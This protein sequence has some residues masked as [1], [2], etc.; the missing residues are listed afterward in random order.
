MISIMSGVANAEIAEDFIHD[1]KE[2]K[3]D[4]E[5][6]KTYAG[7]EGQAFCLSLYCSI[8][9]LSCNTLRSNIQLIP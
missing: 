3:V 8:Y 1:D 7:A 6:K 9:P 5:E 4:K 2:I